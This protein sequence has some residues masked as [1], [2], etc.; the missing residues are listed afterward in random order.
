MS[1]LAA[2]AAAFGQLLHAA[3]VPVT[4]ERSARFARSVVLAEAETSSCLY[5]VGRAT[6][7]SGPEHVDV[8]DRVFRQVF[9][10]LV[11]PADHRGDPNAPPPAHVRPG[12]EQG[13]SSGRT[14]D[15]DGVGGGAPSAAFGDG[16][17]TEDDGDEELVPLGTASGTERLADTDFAELTEAELL[18]LR[19]LMVRLEVALPPRVGRRTRRHPH[20]GAM[21][22][23]ATLRRSHRT[24]GDPVDHVRRRRRTRPRRLVVLLDISGSMEPYAR[25]YVQFLHGA[26]VAARAEVFTFATRLTRLTRVLRVRD[27]QV[28]LRAAAARAPDWQGGT[29]IGEAVR[30]FND[31]WGRRG[32]ARGAVVL[33]VSDGWER[34]DP[35]ILAEQMARLGRL[36]HRVI[37]VNPRRA[38]ERY[39]PLVGGMA[40]A[41][42]HC[43]AFV[44]GHSL[45]ALD[46]VLAELATG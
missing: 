4:P 33:V 46:E 1:D 39:E 38:D 42:P 29:R 45:A 6:L 40:A 30:A 8:Y 15:G 41:L 23:R 26:V 10:G 31:G 19:V 32:L 2:V 36:A 5:W 9:S 12:D 35:A 27:P 37:W 43:D 34:D 16:G 7:L 21:D 13:T 11:D 20:G 25:A 24:A 44:S 14:H 3:G 22:V 17:G 18:A 28:A